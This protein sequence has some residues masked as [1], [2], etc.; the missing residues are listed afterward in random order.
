VVVIFALFACACVSAPAQTTVLPPL[1]PTVGP[2]VTTD[3][4]NGSTLSLLTPPAL[5]C[6]CPMEPAGTP[7]VVPTATPDDGRCHCP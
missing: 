2:N 1:S 3:T 5:I 4:G 6:N 7:T